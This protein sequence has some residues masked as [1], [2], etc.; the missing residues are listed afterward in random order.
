[1]PHGINVPMSGCVELATV[2]NDEHAWSYEEAS[3]PVLVIDCAGDIV[4]ENRHV[5]TV[6]G[7]AK[8]ELL[9]R[10]IGSVIV[11]PRVL[12]LPAQGVRFVRGELLDR[13]GHRRSAELV[14]CADHGDVV[15]I[16][17]AAAPAPL[18]EQD[19]VEIVHDLKSPLATI[20]LETQLLASHVIRAEQVERIERNVAYMDRLVHELLDLCSIDHGQ[21]RVSRRPIELRGLVADVIE[22]MIPSP[23][24]QRVHLEGSVAVVVACDDRRI[25]RVVANLVENALKYASSRGAITV[26]LSVTATHA[27]V[28]VIDAGPGIPAEELA[29]LFDKYR[30]GASAAAV[31]GS[32]IGLY[33][34]RKIVEAHDGRIGVD[35]MPGL[36]SR[37]Y[38]EL[39]VS[40]RGGA[41]VEDAQCRNTLLR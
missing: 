18:R 17:R 25:E 13:A 34:S 21:F 19:V 29:T 35:S 8:G 11:G 6:L 40:A 31:S 37:F 26:R 2:P 7:F 5:E 24:R 14:L 10:T 32:G 22:R 39:P 9:G 4:G 23:L 12:E 27:C 3:D 20:S 33:V 36:G 15:V 28:S 1:L 30:R 41:A 38:F 16:V